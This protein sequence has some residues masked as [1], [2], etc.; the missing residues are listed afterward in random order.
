MRVKN[1]PYGA[2]QL[3]VRHHSSTQCGTHNRLLRRCLRSIAFSCGSS[4][5]S[6]DSPSGINGSPVE[7]PG[8]GAAEMGWAALWQ[9]VCD[10]LQ[11]SA[12]LHSRQH[13]QDKDTCLAGLFAQLIQPLA[14][15]LAESIAQ[16]YAYLHT[17]LRLSAMTRCVHVCHCLSVAYLEIPRL[18]LRSCVDVLDLS[19][20]DTASAAVAAAPHRRGGT[21]FDRAWSIWQATF[22]SVRQGAQSDSVGIVVNTDSNTPL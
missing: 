19:A 3:I 22:E 12:D 2:R 9:A 18:L 14:H 13:R 6:N 15:K 8:G 20:C 11:H 7:V 1:V 16:R 4:S 5:C 17:E 21:R 10:L